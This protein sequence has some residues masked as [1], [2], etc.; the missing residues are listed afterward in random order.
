MPLIVLDI[1]DRSTEAFAGV[2][3]DV[4]PA[5]RLSSGSDRG[6]YMLLVGR[7]ARDRLSADF[8]RHGLDRLRTSTGDDDLA[9]SAGVK[10]RAVVAPIP[11]PPPLTIA[12]SPSSS[13][14]CASPDAAS[15]RAL[16]W[17]SP[18][19]YDS[20][21]L[22]QHADQHRPKRPILLTVDQQF[23]EGAGLWVSP[24]GA[25]AVGESKS[26][27]MRMCAESRDLQ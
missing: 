13:P 26:G 3:H 21:R 22:P 16:G 24:V 10:R 12:T 9:P 20:V 6:A 11:V 18:A 14:I 17:P 4:K 19:D 7:V 1:G 8:G 15:L 5:I 25:D 23:G 27:S 2:H